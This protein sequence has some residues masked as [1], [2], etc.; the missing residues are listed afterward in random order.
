MI[1][2]PYTIAGVAV[3]LKRLTT[4]L[5]IIL[6]G[7]FVFVAASPRVFADEPITAVPHEPATAAVSPVTQPVPTEGGGVA[8]ESPPSEESTSSP[9]PAVEVVPPQINPPVFEGNEQQNTDF[10]CGPA[11][12]AAWIRLLGGE[13]TEEELTLLAQT[14]AEEGTTFL[15]LKN[16]AITKG[17]INAIVYRLSLENIG[18]LTLPALVYLN[19]EGSDIGHYA[20]LYKIEGGTFFLKDPSAGNITKN[21]TE[22]AT[23]FGEYAMINGL[24]APFE[25]ASAERSVNM[26]QAA[27]PVSSSEA[28][29]QPPS[30]LTTDTFAGPRSASV[31]LAATDTEL[32]SVKG[33]WA[34]LIPLVVRG[35]VMRIAGHG[36]HH[37]FRL[38][39]PSKHIQITIFR[40]GVKGSDIN[41]RI[42]YPW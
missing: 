25:P 6:L 13:A 3:R 5:V 33:K 2:S 38:L 11:A 24:L 40:K 12:L 22:F 4:N 17:Y 39:G 1:L 30:P 41:I 35:I 8:P 28:S 23:D 20:V 34:F 36:A 31:P 27:A 32:R 7:I 42:P 16:A 18:Q 15:N 26:A 9:E 10:S 29:T 37:T 21:R 14:N 19:V